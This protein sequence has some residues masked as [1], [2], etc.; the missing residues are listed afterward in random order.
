MKRT[1]A[2]GIKEREGVRAAIRMRKR[3]RETEGDGI[4]KE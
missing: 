1:D 4:K 3:E 2:R